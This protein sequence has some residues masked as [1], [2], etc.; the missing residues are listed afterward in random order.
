MLSVIPATAINYFLNLYWTFGEAKTEATQDA[1]AIRT[2]LQS[3]FGSAALSRF[4]KR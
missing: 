1:K 2:G 3:W 4:I